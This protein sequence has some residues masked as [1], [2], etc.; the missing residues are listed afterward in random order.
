MNIRRG[1][2]EEE[3]RNV[4]EVL[5]E[6][7]RKLKEFFTDFHRVFHRRCLDKTNKGAKGD[8]N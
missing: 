8:G 5:Q 3:G 4:T 2:K 1:R 6:S 7:N